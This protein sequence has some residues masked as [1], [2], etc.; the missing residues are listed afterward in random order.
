MSRA[1]SEMLI[2]FQALLHVPQTKLGISEVMTHPPNEIL[3]AEDASR[4]AGVG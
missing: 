4:A 2:H 1:A 3:P